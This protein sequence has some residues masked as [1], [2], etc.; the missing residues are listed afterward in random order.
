MTW[1]PK[2][3][4]MLCFKVSF[5]GMVFQ[6]KY[7]VTRAHSFESKLFQELCRVFD[8]EKTRT[9]LYHPQS[10]G[11]VERFNRT[12]GDML[13]KLVNIS[14]RNWDE[15]LP[16]VMM[17]YR[18]SV[19]ESTGQSTSS[20]LF[21]HEIQLPID[22]LLGEPPKEVSPSIS[23]SFYVVELKNVLSRIH[24]LAREKMIEASDRQK[25]SYDLRKNFKSYSIGIQSSC[26]ILLVG[27]AQVASCIVLGLVRF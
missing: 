11:L 23:S 19:H 16:Y 25:R 5:L 18:S 17:A 20:M 27:K 14:N 4:Q 15:V 22:L 7:I 6:S 21:G 13:S 10:D 9:T 3:L 12:L 8:I 2:L 1:R 24:D 26:L